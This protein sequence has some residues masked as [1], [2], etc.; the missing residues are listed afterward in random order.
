ML[1]SLI[2]FYRNRV[3]APFYLLMCLFIEARLMYFCAVYFSVLFSAVFVSGSFV[4]A[5]EQAPRFVAVAS[6]MREVALISR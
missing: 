1:I 5:Y 2:Y 4:Y 3:N 6:P